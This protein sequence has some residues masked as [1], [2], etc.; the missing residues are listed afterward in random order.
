M[1]SKVSAQ[2]RLNKVDD[3]ETQYDRCILWPCYE[4]KALVAKADSERS[5]SLLQSWQLELVG[6]GMP[7]PN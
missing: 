4:K 2:T 6:G 7:L 3:L 1:G 5:G